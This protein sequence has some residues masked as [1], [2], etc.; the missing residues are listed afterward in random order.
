M[1]NDKSS[2]QRIALYLSFSIDDL[3]FVIFEGLLTFLRPRHDAGV[4]WSQHGFGGM[5][6]GGI[7]E[8]LDEGNLGA[9]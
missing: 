4:F 2:W 6:V 9:A 8:D 5:L 3:S 1:I 7:G